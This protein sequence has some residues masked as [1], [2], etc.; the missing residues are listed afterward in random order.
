ML[1][2]RIELQELR[3]PLLDQVVGNNDHW[4]IRQAEAVQFHAGCR[5]LVGLA[6]RRR[7]A[8]AAC[9]RFGRA[10]D[11]VFLM[12]V[13]I[14]VAQERAVH[15]REGQVRAV[16]GAQADIVEPVVVEP[17]KA[18]RALLVLPYP[19]AEAVLELL[20]RLAGGNRLLLV[21]DARIFVDL[22]I[23]RRRSA[24]ER[25]VDQVGGKRP[26]RAVGRGV[27]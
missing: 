7:N 18:L 4:L 26:V 21:D 15:A 1:R 10:P 16:I 27:G 23:N 6:R 5:H 19:F 14:V 11:R 8:P 12:R 20:L 2:V 3:A 9:C 17:G 25:V 22:V 24:I 13:E